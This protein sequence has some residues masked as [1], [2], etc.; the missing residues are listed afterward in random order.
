MSLGCTLR[1]HFVEERLKGHIDDDLADVILDL[2]PAAKTIA[3]EVNKAGLVD[4]IGL[5]GTRNVHDE[6]VRKLDVLAND[7]IIDAMR[8]TNRVCGMASEE[9]EELIAPS[10]NGEN[11][12]YVIAFDPLDGSSNIDVGVSIGT[13]FGIYRRNSKSGPATLEDFLRQGS[14]QVAAGYFL[15]GSST[16]LV[17]TARNGVYGFTHDISRGEFLL[18]NKSIKTPSRGKIYSCNEGNSS[19]W[20]DATRR[21]VASLKDKDAGPNR[22]YSSRYVGSFVADFHR[23]LLKGGIFLYPAEQPDPAKAPKAKLRVM[24]EGN[25]MAMIVEHAGGAATDGTRPILEIRP[26][27]I[28]Q[29]CALVIGSKEDVEEYLTYRRGVAGRLAVSN[30]AETAAESPKRERGSRR[31]LEV[32]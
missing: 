18:S 32:G 20:D 9:S 25:P 11:S 10:K 21:Y 23:N 26:E 2:V 29:R 7:L 8:S 27:Q 31:S 28:H 15:Y 16:M 19:K 5:V 6:E 24:Y 22:P 30:E 3:A 17:Y 1:A 14:E 12:R 13:I 4:I